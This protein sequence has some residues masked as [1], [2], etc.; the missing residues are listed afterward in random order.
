MTNLLLDI[1]ERQARQTMRI[2]FLLALRVGWRCQLAHDAFDVV[3]SEFGYSVRQP[4]CQS[5][6]LNIVRTAKVNE[7][8]RFQGST[9]CSVLGAIDAV[10][11]I[12]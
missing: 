9:L 10:K 5:V 1:G 4:C 8:H 7:P 6:Q 3:E 2:V 12:W 11:P